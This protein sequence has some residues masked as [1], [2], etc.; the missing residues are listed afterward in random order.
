MLRTR[1][2]RLRLFPTEYGHVALRR[3]IGVTCEYQRDPSSKRPVASVA[4]GTELSDAPWRPVPTPPRCLA[5]PGPHRPRPRCSGRP[6]ARRT[7]TDAHICPRIDARTHGQGRGHSQQ[8]P[9]R[10]HEQAPEVDNGSF[11]IS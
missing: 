5:P 6:T 11:H 3:A 7:K 9:R 10:S 4:F 1:A 2:F 8:R